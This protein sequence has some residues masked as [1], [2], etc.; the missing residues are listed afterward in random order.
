VIIA[1]SIEGLVSLLGGLA[2]PLFTSGTVHIPYSLSAALWVGGISLVA[3]LL[4][5]ALI[6]AGFGWARVAYIVILVISLLGLVAGRQPIS[7]MVIT[8]VKVILFSY[9]FFRREANEYLAKCAAA[10]AS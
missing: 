6:L 4:L 5:A 9:F 2:T 7:L 8:G 10:D 3:N 1:V